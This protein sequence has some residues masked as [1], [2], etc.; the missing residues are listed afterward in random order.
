MEQLKHKL[1]I[2]ETERQALK[3]NLREEEVARI[4]AEGLIALPVSQDQDD[5]AMYSPRKQSPSKRQ[6]PLSDDKE[7]MRIMPKKLSET[8][9]LSRELE[10]EKTRRLRAEGMVEF[11]KM[12]C[13]FQCCACKT[14]SRL[15]HKLALSLDAELAAGIEKIRESMEDIFAPAKIVASPDEMEVEGVEVE[16]FAIEDAGQ[17]EA[18][19]VEQPGDMLMTDQLALETGADVD[20]V[21]VESALE[22]DLHSDARGLPGST[23]AT[24]DE[25]ELQIEDAS[26]G[27]E[28][29]STPQP[30]GPARN[31]Q[32]STRPHPSVRTVTTTTTIPTHFTP[33]PKLSTFQRADGDDAEPENAETPTTP[34]FDRAA[35]LAAIEYRR[36]R[37]KSIANGHVTPRKQMVEGVKERR[38]ISAPALGQKSGM[39]AAA[40]GMREGP[41]S[42]GRAGG[43]RLG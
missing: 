28:Q 27:S 18:A 31:K 11:M 23:D 6:S 40:A 25:A 20:S 5:D 29:P 36:G 7:N 43:R 30:P 15:G 9:E 34:S 22:E 13:L 3:T 16:D 42:V 24:N 39:K 35:A 32:T 38:D 41:S 21:A 12:E 2:A 37:A 17:A 33:N 1:N 8:R 4:A 19:A 14:S 26:P 10:Q